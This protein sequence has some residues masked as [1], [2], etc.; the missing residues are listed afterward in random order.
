LSSE[1]AFLV[2]EGS[3]DGGTWG[4]EAKTYGFPVSDLLAVG[5]VDLS[6]LLFL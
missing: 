2:N 1:W 6:V 4:G 3:F 5:I